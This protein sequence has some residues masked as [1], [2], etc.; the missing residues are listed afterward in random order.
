ME[1]ALVV[2]NSNSSAL[3]DHLGHDLLIFIVRHA[4]G[5]C[6]FPAGRH[7]AVSQTSV[8]F[9]RTYSSVFVLRFVTLPFCIETRVKPIYCF[10]L[11]NVSMT[12]I[13]WKCLKATKEGTFV[14]YAHAALAIGKTNDV[15]HNSML[16]AKHPVMPECKQ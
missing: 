7:F 13:F 5:L 3:V 12:K 9:N 4:R 6:L 1:G 15:S 10:N 8:V 16:E 2:Y 14:L 11:F